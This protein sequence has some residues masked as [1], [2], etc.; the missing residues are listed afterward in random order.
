MDG[1]R[2]ITGA[3][4]A[5]ICVAVCTG[6][7]AVATFIVAVFAKQAA[8][9]AKKTE[10]EAMK[11]SRAALAEA[12]ATSKLAKATSKLAEEATLDRELSWSRYLVRVFYSER[13]YA[14]TFRNLGR[15]P[16]L[17]CFYYECDPSDTGSWRYAKFFGS[18]ST[19]SHASQRKWPIPPWG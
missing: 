2:G 10:G 11:T 3:T 16:A 9:E 15:G 19:A 13:P 18:V 1:S 6:L 7:L 8:D 17:R 12:E 4:W 14:M 5:A